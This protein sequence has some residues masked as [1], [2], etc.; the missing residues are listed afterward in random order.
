[1]GAPVGDEKYAAQP[2]P[3]V[4]E[5]TKGDEHQVATTSPNGNSSRGPQ[6][7]SSN[8]TQHNDGREGGEGTA[9]RSDIQS[10][11]AQE[12][13]GISVSDAQNGL[14]NAVAPQVSNAATQE[15]VPSIITNPGDSA[16]SPDG[17]M[18]QSSKPLTVEYA[19]LPQPNG[20]AGTIL[21]ATLAGQVGQ[22]ELR[23]GIQ[24]GEFGNVDIRTSV[25]RN[26]LTAE[27][28]VEHS[29]L[30]H[31]LAVDL[32]HLQTKL[33]EYPLTTTNI[34]LGNYAGDS[35]TGSRHPNQPEP[36]VPNAMTPKQSDL[37]PLPALATSAETQTQPA[38]LDVH[39]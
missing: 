16:Q 36:R 25:I 3:V 14:S 35:S 19:E 15:T 20:S 10:N 5:A 4:T 29:E 28:S 2:S 23:V 37:Q 34:I 11:T 33:A 38:H 21:A 24:A 12:G 39:M 22:S 27:I 8:S 13:K 1:I 17:A 32:P 30:R 26:Q 18:L 7:P 9:Q 31:L 6:L